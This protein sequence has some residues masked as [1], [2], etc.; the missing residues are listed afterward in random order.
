MMKDHTS[1]LEQRISNEYKPGIRHLLRLF[2]FAFSSAKGI[3]F[4]FLGL[5][6]LLSLLQPVTAWLW[7]S[8]VE[9]ADAPIAEEL[10]WML[11][12]FLVVFLT[13]LLNRY[14]NAWEQIERL[15]VVQKNRFEEKMESRMYRKLS[16]L[17]MENFEAAKIN[18]RVE[19]VFGFVMNGWDGLNREVMA[20]GYQIIAMTVSVCCLTAAL[21]IVH[22]TLALIALLA[23]VPTLYSTFVANKMQARFRR[24]NAAEKRKSAYFEG[25]LLGEAQK[26][27]KSLGLGDFLYGKWESV[28][29]RY[30]K[31]EMKTQ[32]ASALIGLS[33]NMVSSL[34]TAG[35]TVYAIILMTRGELTVGQ[36]SAAILM[37]N[38]LL[39]NT[40]A[41]FGR[42]GA[43]LSKKVDAAAFFDLMDLPEEEMGADC[44]TIEEI[45]LENVSYRY[46]MTETY[47]LQDVS[48]TIRR[49]ERVALVGE[50]GAGK[51]TF[52]K[53]I[54][55]L[56]DPSQGCITVNGR[57]TAGNA[58]RARIATVPQERERYMG[59]SAGENVILGDHTKGNLV[60]LRDSMEFAGLTDLS[61]DTYLGKEL[62][63]T[64]L[65]GGQWQ[66]LAIA[67]CRYRDR[68]IMLLDEPTGNLDPISEAEVFE[69]Y[70]D[71]SRGRTLLMVT[72][73]ISV[74]ALADRILVFSGGHVVEDGNH[75]A[76]MEHNGEYARLYREQAKWYADRDVTKEKA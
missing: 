28:T 8:F 73:R 23:P 69:K 71:I 59:L 18:D 72:H 27:I 31:N 47:A 55:G 43:F 41:L 44:G 20:A 42:I 67:R 7:G 12:Y 35:A 10:G 21:Y 65:S 9:N 38:Q 37:V 2:W 25:L 19:R 68:E 33:S 49:G 61:P 51:T 64:D 45:R 26:E 66:K 24:D 5:C 76:L 52:V 4:I 22:P 46:P 32:M 16:R 14:T 1:L 17:H 30:A 11:A 57:E 60:G 50:N 70:M 13:G 58:R 53:L 15:D 34:A 56:A 3:C 39:S 29:R 36:L 54:T 74:A 62:G 40:G 75:H 48:V 6:L 63:G